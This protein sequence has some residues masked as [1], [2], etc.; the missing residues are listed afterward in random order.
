MSSVRN[1]SQPHNKKLAQP[2][3]LTWNTQCSKYLLGEHP[4]HVL[5]RENLARDRHYICQVGTTPT[6]RGVDE[7]IEAGPQDPDLCLSGD[8]P[9]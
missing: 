9:P 2:C 6:Q 4:P 1:L 3:E 8:D 5:Q 7:G